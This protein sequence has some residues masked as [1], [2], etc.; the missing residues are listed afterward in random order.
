MTG[1]ESLTLFHISGISLASMIF[2]FIVA[3]FVPLFTFIYFKKKNQSTKKMSVLVGALTFIIFALVLEKTMNLAV[4]KAFGDVFASNIWPYA[5]YGGLAAG[6]F[7]ETGRFLSMKYLMKNS[8]DKQN[9]IMYGIGHGGIESVILVG[10]TY[11]S[12]IVIAI[13]MNN[14]PE[15]KIL[16]LM[17]KK[18]ALFHQMQAIAA[19]PAFSLCLV[20]IERIAAFAFQISLS[21]LVYKSVAEKKIQLF[22]AAIGLHFFIDAS[23]FIMA[24]KLSVYITELYLLS[25][26]FVVSFFIFKSYIKD[27]RETASGQ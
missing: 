11:L 21:Y 6:I 27:Q 12:L 13:Y 8:L 20:G 1:T 23:A 26:V 7:E 5:V 22:I 9:S 19:A 4:F 18:P 14:A 24:K 15:G 16:I 2:V 17:A 3:V 10:L 25:V